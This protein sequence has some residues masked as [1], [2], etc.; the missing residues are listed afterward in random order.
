MKVIHICNLEEIG[1]YV[2]KLECT[3]VKNQW[4]AAILFIGQNYDQTWQKFDKSNSC[5]KFGR[6]LVIND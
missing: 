2:T 1:L 3:Q 6:N 4:E 5:M